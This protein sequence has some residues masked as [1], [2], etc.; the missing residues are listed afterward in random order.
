MTS[1]TALTGRTGKFAIGSSLV[2]RT[3]TWTTNPTM[4]SGSEWGDS[5]SAGFTNRAAGRRDS[6][7]TS[8]GVYDTSDQVFDLFQPGDITIATLWMDNLTLYFDYPRALATDFSLVVDID[9]E[10]VVA[11]T[12]SHGADGV[13]HRPGEAG[14]ASRV[15]P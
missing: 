9:T 11:W 3:K 14:A 1:E 15:L 7:F 8:E 10:E 2:A 4:A 12:A 6:T 13:F 5:N